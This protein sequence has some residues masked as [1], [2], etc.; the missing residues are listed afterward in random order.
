[1]PAIILPDGINIRHSTLADIDSY[2]ALR[3]EALKNH[4]SAF[5]QDYDE[6]LLR[7]REYW[8]KVLTIN[9]NEQALFFAEQNGQLVGMTGIFRSLSRKNLHSATIWGVYVTSAWRGRHISEALIHSCLDWAMA[10]GVSIV[11]LAVETNNLQAV[12]CYERCGF[13]TYGTEPKAIRHDGIYYD[14]YLMV[15]EI[16]PAS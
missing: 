6:N 3:L 14:E 7:P 15:L 4:P 8:E 2:R 9:S 12:N 16:D 13:T 1:M 11:K 5:G 10:H